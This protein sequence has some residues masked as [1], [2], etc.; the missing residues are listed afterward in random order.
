MHVRVWTCLKSQNELSN[1]FEITIF[2]K[3]V[4]FPVDVQNCELAR[5]ASSLL[6]GLGEEAQRVICHLSGFR[7]SAASQSRIALAAETMLP[8]F[9]FEQGPGLVCLAIHSYTL[10]FQKKRTKARQ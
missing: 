10:H 3:K 7:S 5:A 2:K 1:I 9:G 6:L 8:F 4:K